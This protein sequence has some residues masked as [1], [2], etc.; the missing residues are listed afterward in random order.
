VVP[1]SGV[2]EW[3]PPKGGPQGGSQRGVPQAGVRLK[4]GPHGG[5]P[6]G[7]RNEGQQRGF[8]QGGVPQGWSAKKGPPSGVL[9]VES[10]KAI[11]QGGSLKGGP[12]NFRPRGVHEGGPVIPK[13]VPPRVVPQGGFPRGILKESQAMAFNIW[14]PN[15]V[16]QGWSAEGA[17]N[18]NPHGFTSRVVPEWRF[19]KGGSTKCFPPNG[20]PKCGPHVRPKMGI[21]KAVHPMG[22]P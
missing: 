13:G 16:P 9:K 12:L 15:S 11:T 22:V 3:C 17:P 19:T 8:H 4:E 5:P 18:R 2:P 6:K 1:K 10:H 14:G 21:P 7:Y 20:S